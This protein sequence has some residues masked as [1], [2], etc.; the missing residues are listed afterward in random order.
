[1]TSSLEIALNSTSNVASFQ[2]SDPVDRLFAPK[3]PELRVDDLPVAEVD[4]RLLRRP[5]QVNDAALARDLE[6]LQEVD[7][8]HVL[9]RSREAGPPRQGLRRGGR[10]VLLR[11]PREE[12]VD[13][14]DELA[15]EDGL[16]E[17]VL[18][19]ELEPAN[20]VL[21][22]LLARQEDD[23]DRLPTPADP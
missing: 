19:A 5:A 12:E 10:D 20:L 8:R 18:D 13:S 11:T 15:N 14:G 9:R 1:M 16:R 17:V 7:H 21:D 4:V 22:R 3:A 23:G 6:R 2:M